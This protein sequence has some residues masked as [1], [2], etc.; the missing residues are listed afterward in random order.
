MVNSFK[1]LFY[2]QPKCYSMMQK[3]LHSNNN[4]EKN[5]TKHE[6]FVTSLFFS[7]SRIVRILTE[8]FFVTF[9]EVARRRKTNLI[10]DFRNGQV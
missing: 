6:R 1:L 9:G 7:R 5:V 10:S 8:I 3:Y 4:Y 2:K